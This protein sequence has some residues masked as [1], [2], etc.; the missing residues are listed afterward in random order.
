VPFIA[1]A[2][3]TLTVREA[4]ARALAASFG[5]LPMALSTS[6]GA[7]VQRPLAT[8]VIGLVSATGLTLFLLPLVYPWFA[9]K[10]L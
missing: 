7:E 8:V 4:V 2:Q 10:D 9:S 5:F 3:P 6:P 1:G